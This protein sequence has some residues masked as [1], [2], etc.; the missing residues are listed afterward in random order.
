MES[1]LTANAMESHLTA[2][3]M[4]SH[5]TAN[6]MESHPTPSVASCGCGSARAGG[7]APAL[8]LV[9]G[10]PP[11]ADMRRS[12]SRP[13]AAAQPGGTSDGANRALHE[14][15]P[16]FRPT[17]AT[18]STVTLFARFRGLSTS[19]PRITAAWYAS[20][21]SGT[22]VTIGCSGSGTSGT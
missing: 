6:A 4:E 16:R 2:N 15:Q 20:N 18:Y 17:P 22:T 8:M 7:A 11:L 14:Q 13:A 21:C 19:L 1:H 10:K 9:P 5:L 12:S 3:A